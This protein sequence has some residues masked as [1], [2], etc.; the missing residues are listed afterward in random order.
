[1]FAL[2]SK[3]LRIVAEALLHP[4]PLHRALPVLQAV[5]AGGSSQM[6][7]ALRGERSAVHV[8]PLGSWNGTVPLR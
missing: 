6:C 3:P 4:C 1:M 7:R 8:G 2:G 5:S